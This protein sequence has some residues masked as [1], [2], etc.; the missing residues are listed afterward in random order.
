M[1]IIVLIV[2]FLLIIFLELPSLLKEKLYKEVLA[3]SVVLIVGIFMSLANFYNWPI[4]NPIEDLALF[5]SKY[6][7]G[8]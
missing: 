6:Y 5:L 4:Y 7:Y 1:L 8:G 2:I 3:F